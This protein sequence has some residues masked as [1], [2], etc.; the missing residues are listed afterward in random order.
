M[1]AYT[2]YW[3]CLYILSIFST[4]INTYLTTK[5]RVNVV[6]FSSFNI[7]YQILNISFMHM[8]IMLWTIFNIK[9]F[10]WCLNFWP[11]L[12]PFLS[13]AFCILFFLLILL[14]F[15]I[16]SSLLYFNFSHA[17]YC[18]Q[19]FLVQRYIIFVKV[20]SRWHVRWKI[21]ELTKISRET[22]STVNCFHISV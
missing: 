12:Y 19:C 10:M 13:L 21:R 18:G 15:Q 3:A 9:F 4:K 11:L 2:Y 5:T 16:S 14:I 20:H 17:S 22:S 7:Y 6:F 8:S 1:L